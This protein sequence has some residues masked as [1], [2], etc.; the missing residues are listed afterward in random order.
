MVSMK[1]YPISDSKLGVGY[2]NRSSTVYPGTNPSYI[3]SLQN[4]TNSG[5]KS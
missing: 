2:E 4:Y 1:F 3:Q 5:M